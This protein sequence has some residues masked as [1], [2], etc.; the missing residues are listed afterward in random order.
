MDSRRRGFLSGGITVCGFA[1]TS[2]AGLSLSRSAR[3]DN[4][5]SRQRLIEAVGQAWTSR[6]DFAINEQWLA[7]GAIYHMSPFSDFKSAAELNG[8]IKLFKQGFPDFEVVF[9]EHLSEGTRSCHRWHVSGTYTGET[10]I[11]KVPP[12]GKRSV[13]SGCHIVHWSGEKAAEVWHIGD[14]LG[15]LQSAGIIPAG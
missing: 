12:T 13:T 9:D 10:P 5:G 3:A 1:M 6:G 2:I 7:D 11:F 14:W 15:G 8:F 4:N